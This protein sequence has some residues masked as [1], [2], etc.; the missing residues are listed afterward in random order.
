[1]TVLTDRYEFEEG[2]NRLFIRFSSDMVHIDTACGAVLLFLKSRGPQF[3]PHLFAVNLG[4]REALANAVR[5]G[6]KCNTDKLVSLELDLSRRDW[7]RLVVH[8]QGPG[9]DWVHLQDEVVPDEADHGRGMSIMRTY[10]DRFSYNE[11]GNILY[12]EKRIL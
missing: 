6:N 5:H 12:L 1:M 11:K 2:A 10:F 3:F 8:D 7:L 4:M 9:F